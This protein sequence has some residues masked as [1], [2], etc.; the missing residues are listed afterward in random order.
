MK[1]NLERND[2]L[3]NKIRSI[4]TRFK[5]DST[6]LLSSV[7]FF[8]LIKNYEY[9]IKVKVQL[10]FITQTIGWKDKITVIFVSLTIILTSDFFY[11]TKHNFSPVVRW[12]R[13]YSQLGIPVILSIHLDI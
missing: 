1:H 9:L 4:W 12:F 13:R 3:G 11:S 6:L 5:L 2:H 10:D 7:I 8:L